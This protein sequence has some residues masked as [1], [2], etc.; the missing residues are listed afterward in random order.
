MLLTLRTIVERSDDHSIPDMHPM[1]RFGYAVGILGM[2]ALKG[3]YTVNGFKDTICHYVAALKRG[4]ANAD[5]NEL[6]STL[7]S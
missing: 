7:F 6:I 4:V 1:K 2:A 5:T 3:N